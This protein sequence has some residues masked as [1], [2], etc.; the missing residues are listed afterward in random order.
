MSPPKSL[1]PC[2]TVSAIL[3]RT[4]LRPHLLPAFTPD[5]MNLDS[6]GFVFRSYFTPF[7]FSV[8]FYLTDVFNIKSA[9][10]YL[11]L[12][13]NNLKLMLKCWIHKFKLTYTYKY[14]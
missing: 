3:L 8:I 14:V 13:F 7:S 2:S 12:F 1:I 5:S 11:F 6:I 10:R 4:S 9:V